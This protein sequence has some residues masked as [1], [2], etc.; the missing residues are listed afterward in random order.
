M[1]RLLLA[2]AASAWAAKAPPEMTHFNE[3]CPAPKACEDLARTSK[4]CKSKG[5]CKPFVETMKALAPEYDCQRPFDKTPTD[6]YIVPALWLCE[7]GARHA[8]LKLLSGLKSPEARRFFASEGFRG[9]LDGE[10][11]ALYFDRSRA[12]ERRLNVK[13]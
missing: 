12:L 3:T 13:K 7:D 9:V 8:S 1:S 11:A 10:S 5:D 2:L 4:A 6:N